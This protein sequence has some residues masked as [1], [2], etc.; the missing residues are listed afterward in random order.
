MIMPVHLSREPL[1]HPARF[2]V[3]AVVN[4]DDLGD[5]VALK[6]YIDNV[7]HPNTLV[8]TGYYNRERE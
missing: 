8:V 2:Q 4:H 6:Q 7:T 3:G 5:V 1:D